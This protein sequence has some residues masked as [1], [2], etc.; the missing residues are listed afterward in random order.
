MDRKDF[1]RKAGIGT[2]G[3]LGSSMIANPAMACSRSFQQ[4]N[5]P[6][7]LLIMA[8]DMGFSDLGSFG[9][10]IDTPNIDRLAR[11]GLTFS[12]F[13]NNAR[14][15]PSRASLLTGL[16]PHQTGMGLMTGDFGI[17]GYRGE[18]N[19]HCV[20]IAEALEQQGYRSAAAGK[21]HLSHFRNVD[22]MDEKHSW[23]LQRGFDDFY[24][25]INGAGSYYDP[26]FLHEGN[27]PVSISSDP[28]YFTD[29]ITRRGIGYIDNYLQ[30]D[31]PFF[32]YM[33][34]TAPHWPLHALEEDIE[35]YK[36][37]FSEGWDR[38]RETRYRKL[39][40]KGIIDSDWPLT[41]R[42]PRVDAWKKTEN[43][44]WEARR[45][46]VYAAQMDRMDQNIGNILD[47]L[48]ENGE[49]ENTMVIF[50]ADNGG[51][52]ERLSEGWSRLP[53]IPTETRDGRK[54]HVGNNPD[55]MP[56]PE[57][58]Y[59]SYGVP[60]ANVSNTPFRLYKHWIHEGGIATP[61]I[62][63]WPGQIANEGGMNNEVGHISDIMATCL[64][65]AGASYPGQYEGNDIHPL[66][67]KSLMPLLEGSSRDGHDHI[68]WEHHGNRAIRKDELKLVF[69]GET[70][71]K[72]EPGTPGQWE[73]YNMDKD[74][75]E[76][77][78]LASRYPGKTEQLKSLYRSWADR[79]GVIPQDKL[80]EMRD[81][82]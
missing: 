71:W 16:Y 76:M 30:Q 17:D 47:Y 54:V 77:N 24:G 8:D 74:R 70:Q 27:D 12:Q 82:N 55:Y 39:I 51:S 35:K 20:T 7:I 45:M 15:C 11:R 5:P 33:A 81:D 72:I 61:L 4:E 48:E 31:H 57:T 41:S 6:N 13:Y 73:L 34:Y 78:N 36:G 26:A 38:L 66:E 10:L 21:W 69:R 65:A 58:T 42:D 59:Q 53:A 60:W 32:L 40:D 9:A 19:N 25:I 63:S 1:L 64:D 52:A 56:G 79:T 23:P 67:G 49:R 37:V 18:L 62:I 2:A 75:T 43:K 29:V 80:Q 50:L 44:D 28:Y 3:I 22:T 68:G 46:A 14:C